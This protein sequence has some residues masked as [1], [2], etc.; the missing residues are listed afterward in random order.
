M[1][2]F[3]V[4]YIILNVMIYGNVFD[5]FSELMNLLVVKYIFSILIHWLNAILFDI[6]YGLFFF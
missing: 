6:V 5:L 1:Y 2:L 4:K 3:I